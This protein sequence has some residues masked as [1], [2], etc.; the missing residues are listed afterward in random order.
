MSE[1]ISPVRKKLFNGIRPR[2]KLLASDSPKM[3]EIKR[4]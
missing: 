3:V 4:K 2:E 1:D